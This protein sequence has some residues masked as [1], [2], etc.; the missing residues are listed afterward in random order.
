MPFLWR[1]IQGIKKKGKKEPGSMLTLSLW[2]ASLKNISEANG[3]LACIN[4]SNI[5]N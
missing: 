4:H 2:R 3:Y 1:E 5:H